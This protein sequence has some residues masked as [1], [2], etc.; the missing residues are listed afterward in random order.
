MTSDT[1]KVTVYKD[2]VGNLYLTSQLFSF[3]LK[4][5]GKAVPVISQ[6]LYV[7]LHCDFINW[8]TKSFCKVD[9][10]GGF[11][12]GKPYEF[13]MV[14]SNKLGGV[15]KDW[16]YTL[17]AE[18]ITDVIFTDVDTKYVYKFSGAHGNRKLIACGKMQSTSTSTFY[19]LINDYDKKC[20]KLVELSSSNEVYI[21]L[22][23]NE[24][25]IVNFSFEGGKLWVELN[26][27]S[28][29]II[30][31]EDLDNFVEKMYTVEVKKTFIEL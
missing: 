31:P 16:V 28:I 10:Y 27:G 29:F 12:G 24:Q 8:I 4:Y 30:S 20:L 22:L 11:E 14:V 17:N 1:N 7:R 23:D 15:G 6:T 19:T 13:N 18:R 26:S 9:I 3:V 21:N 5:N 2:A 25:K